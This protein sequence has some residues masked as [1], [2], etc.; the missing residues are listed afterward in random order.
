[1]AAFIGRRRE[2]WLEISLIENGSNNGRLAVSCRAIGE[3]TGLCKTAAADAL[4][5]LVNAGFLECVERLGRSRRR[6]SLL[7]ID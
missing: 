2:G 7:N 6:N 5:E 1:M 3:R 4:R